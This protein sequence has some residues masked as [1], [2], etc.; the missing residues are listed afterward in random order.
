MTKAVIF[1]IGNVLIEWQPER[2]Y[3][4]VIGPTRRK[5]M[6]AAID[7][8]AM[9]DKVD[10]GAHFQ[11]V[12][13]AEAAANPEW[14]A[15]V[16]MW[17]DNWLDLATPA[18]DHSVRLLDALK[19]TGVPVF[20]LTNFGKQTFEIAEPVYPFLKVFDRRYVSGH[21]GVIKP[22]SRIYEMVEE[23]CGLLPSQLLFTDDRQDNI[24]AASARG[25]QTHLFEGPAG[26]ALRLVEEGLLTEDAAQ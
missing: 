14:A 5:A 25:W 4:R 13:Y 9:N 22:E 6:F 20:A 15:E 21:M 19:S 18:I 3:D 2:Y 23:D 7:L 26:F 1:D 11:D 12:V 16:R 8:H 24:D 10:R 17:H